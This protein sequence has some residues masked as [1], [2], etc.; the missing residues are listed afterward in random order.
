MQFI[1]SLV[2]NFFLYMGIIIVFILAIP[3]LILP[4]R[5]ALYCGKFLAYYIIVI[6]KLFLK[7]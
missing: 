1:R 5:F 7:I 4:A 3:T 2:F 6:L